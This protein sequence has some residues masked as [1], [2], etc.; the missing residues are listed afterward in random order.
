MDLVQNIEGGTGKNGKDTNPLTSVT[1]V[2]QGK[3]L[4]NPFFHLV[5]IYYSYRGCFLLWPPFHR[6]VEEFLWAM[7]Y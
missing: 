6:Q 4:L 7:Q 1:K 2:Q 3:L 5:F